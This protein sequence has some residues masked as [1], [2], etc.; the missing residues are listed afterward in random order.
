MIMYH[1]YVTCTRR[2]VHV[3]AGKQKLLIE[4]SYKKLKVIDTWCIPYL[5]G[6]PHEMIKRKMMIARWHKHT[7]KLSS[8]FWTPQF[9][10]LNSLDQALWA[11]SNLIDSSS[12]WIDF[13]RS[14]FFTQFMNLFLAPPRTALESKFFWNDHSGPVECLGASSLKQTTVWNYQ[15]LF[16]YFLTVLWL[17]NFLGVRLFRALGYWFNRMCDSLI[18]ASVVFC[19]NKS[20]FCV[21]PQ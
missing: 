10:R 7:G 5:S 6:G 14:E 17:G 20:N 18:E 8:I 1:G 19:S 21:H 2:P 4:R 15:F 3:L 9:D 11:N 13:Y 16:W 12:L